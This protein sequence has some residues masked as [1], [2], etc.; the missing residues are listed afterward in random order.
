MTG[1]TSLRIADFC[2]ACTTG[3]ACGPNCFANR[4]RRRK[5]SPNL[6][7]NRRRK[8]PRRRQPRRKRKTLRKKKP[9]K[10]KKPPTAK[11]Y[12]R[13]GNGKRPGH[14]CPGLFLSQV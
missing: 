7:P 5:W 14:G 3:I 6:L 2:S 12:D 1:C 9:R 10:E 4:R 8:E 13:G 11:S